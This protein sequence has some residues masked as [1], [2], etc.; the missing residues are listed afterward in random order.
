MLRRALAVTAAAFILAVPVLAEDVPNPPPTEGVEGMAG[1]F[2][3]NQADGKSRG[4][5]VILYD[6]AVANA[7]Y[8]VELADDCTSQ[9]EFL[10][11]VGGWDRSDDDGILIFTKNGDQMFHFSPAQDAI[12]RGTFDGDKHEYY[13]ERTSG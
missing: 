10:K 11:D 5:A 6:E 1:Q 7:L 12:Y 3:F 8:K 2:A 9:F 13:L 4:C